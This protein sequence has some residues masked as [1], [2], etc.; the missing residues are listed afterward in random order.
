MQIFGKVKE[1]F[2]A[3]PDLKA[4]ETRLNKFTGQENNP[5]GENIN[6]IEGDIKDLT[7]KFLKAANNNQIEGLCCIK[8]PETGK[9]LL[10]ITLK[11]TSKPYIFLHE[12]NGTFTDI[13]KAAHQGLQV[14]QILNIIEADGPIRAKEP[15]A[16][17]IENLRKAA[18]RNEPNIELEI[19][20]AKG[21]FTTVPLMR[22]TELERVLSTETLPTNSLVQCLVP[23]TSLEEILL[24]RD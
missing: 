6:P 17:S 22:D 4:Q 5:E 18:D 9:S 1:F 3:Q 15:T 2:G 24:T 7:S 19:K 10:V 21:E 12:G 11:D 23:D 13:T 20:H 14:T 16:F 8:N